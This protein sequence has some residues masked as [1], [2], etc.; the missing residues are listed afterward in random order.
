[1][2]P[3]WLKPRTWPKAPRRSAAARPREAPPAPLGRTPPRR[4]A[5]GSHGL[6]DPRSQAPRLRR[7]GAPLRRGLEVRR[8]R[9]PH[10]EHRHAEGPRAGAVPRRLRVWARPRPGPARG[11][12]PAPGG[13]VGGQRGGEERGA[14]RRLPRRGRDD[15]PGAGGGAAAR[16]LLPQSWGQHAA[17][18]PGLRPGPHG[19]LQVREEQGDVQ[20]LEGE[21]EGEAAEAP[22]AVCGGLRRRGSGGH[23]WRRG[24]RG[25][26]WGSSRGDRFRRNLVRRGSQGSGVPAA[27]RQGAEREGRWRLGARRADA[28]TASRGLLGRSGCAPG[29][30]RV[31]FWRRAS[32][33]KSDPGSGLGPDGAA[34][35]VG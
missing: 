10:A 7:Q 28:G 25:G 18:R 30:H 35:R 3:F 11:R 16:C 20:R 8:P 24:Q 32:R 26:P 17:L 9:W 31:K 6:R 34:G 19:L 5:K 23:A 33:H 12:G 14:E 22:P 13:G 4:P 29:A 1:L 2:K 15:L 27:C 21:D